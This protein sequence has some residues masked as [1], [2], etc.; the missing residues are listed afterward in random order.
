MKLN[1]R[2]LDLELS[3]THGGLKLIAEMNTE[4]IDKNKRN[5]KMK[6]RIKNKTENKINN[7][8]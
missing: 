8:V 6:R 5:K 3:W 1:Y 4:N 2:T 7:Y